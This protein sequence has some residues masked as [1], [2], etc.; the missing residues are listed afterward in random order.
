MYRAIV[1]TNDKYN[2]QSQQGIADNYEKKTAK[3][4]I[5]SFN[6]RKNVVVRKANEIF[7]LLYLFYHFSCFAQLHF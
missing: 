6:T 2:V 7:C 4:K 3:P 5:P 1:S